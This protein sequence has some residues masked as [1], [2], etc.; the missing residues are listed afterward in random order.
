VW[1]G[2]QADKPLRPYICLQALRG[3]Q[4]VYNAHVGLKTDLVEPYAQL[5]STITDQ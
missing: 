1:D 3:I 2:L 5:A 4:G